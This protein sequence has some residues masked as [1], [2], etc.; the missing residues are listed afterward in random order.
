MAR[1][2]SPDFKN[3][4]IEKLARRENKEV[5]DYWKRLK[6]TMR[7]LSRGM[8]AN[9]DSQVK[10]N[11]SSL[12]E[13]IKVLDEKAENQEPSEEEWARYRLEGEMEDILTYE[14]TIWQQRRNEQWVLKGDSNSG[15]FHSVANG[16]KRKRTIFSLDF[17]A[18]EISDPKALREHVEC[19]Y[20]HLFG[21]EDRGKTSLQE[22]ISE[23][24]NSLSEWKQ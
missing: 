5:Q 16:R 12:L 17:E 10:K 6:K 20:K 2:S 13:K 23:S 1:L 19:Y 7:Q 8:G 18:G 21:R 15:F 9:L 4:M 22:D 11:K 14:E 24:E 3:K